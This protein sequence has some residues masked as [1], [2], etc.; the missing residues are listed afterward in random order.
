MAAPFRVLRKLSTLGK[1]DAP[2]GSKKSLGH[3]RDRV[4]SPTVCGKADG[5]GGTKGGKVLRAKASWR[6]LRYVAAW[7]TH[8]VS[9]DNLM[10][11]FARHFPQRNDLTRR[12]AEEMIFDAHFARTKRFCVD[13]DE[14][15]TCLEMVTMEEIKNDE[16]T[17]SK[18]V[19]VAVWRR[20]SG[21]HVHVNE[22][23][24]HHHC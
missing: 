4:R 9:V 18:R 12:D 16:S 3:F 6:R 22:I 24:H 21:V 8:G 15:I 1:S 20:P 5:G 7:H 2:V 11:A 17:D 13:L 19:A 10:D 23:G 14:L